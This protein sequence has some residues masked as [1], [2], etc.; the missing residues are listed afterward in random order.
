MTFTSWGWDRLDNHRPLG[1]GI[2]YR[3]IAPHPEA[4]VENLESPPMW[5]RGFRRNTATHRTVFA[6]AASIRGET[7]NYAKAACG[8]YSNRAVLLVDVNED[9]NFCDDCLLD[10]FQPTVV[11]RMWNAADHLI[12]VGSTADLLVRLYV[13]S[14]QTWWFAQA[15]RVTYE[16]HPTEADAR[17]AE[18]IA[19]KT[20]QPLYNRQ[21]RHNWQPPAQKA[22]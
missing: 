8:R 10:G 1:G 13:H 18:S 22:A 5:Y 3:T 12:Y 14:R 9:T 19:I 15:V 4:T 6:S 16:I 11:Y 17:I 21:R 20:E 2:S 7:A